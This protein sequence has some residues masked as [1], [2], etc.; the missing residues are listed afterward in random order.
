MNTHLL[1]T[2][3]LIS[4][5]HLNNSRIVTFSNSCPFPISVGKGDSD[6]VVIC[7]NLALGETCDWTI[8]DSGW[9]GR[10]YRV[11]PL[12]TASGLPDPSGFPSATLAEY[13]FA[14]ACP[15]GSCSWN[16]DWFDISIIPPGCPGSA[17]SYD[18]CVADT[19]VGGYDVG[20]Q[21]EALACPELPPT[22]CTSVA[23]AGAY[24]FPVDNTKTTVCQVSGDWLVTFC[25]GGAN[26]L[27]PNTMSLLESATSGIVADGTTITGN[28][29]GLSTGGMVGVVLGA[30]VFVALL[31]IV[32]VVVVRRKRQQ[33][34]IV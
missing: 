19:G 9:S 4:L 26:N 8:P 10:F 6:N 17:Q 32:I 16:W 13:S 23:C 27:D 34:E 14:Y 25:P 31:A 24:N 5:P 28:S 20:M 2:I 15:S 11:N 29:G 1:L 21:M 18:E 7:D 3:L 12:T 33:G 22:I 30:V